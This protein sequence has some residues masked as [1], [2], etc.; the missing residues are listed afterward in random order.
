MITLKMHI[1]LKLT[2]IYLGLVLNLLL[3]KTVLEF[4]KFDQR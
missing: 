4:A 1:L 2:K 3:I